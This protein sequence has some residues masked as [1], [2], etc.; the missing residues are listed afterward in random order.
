MDEYYISKDTRYGPS[1][2]K[3]NI[4]WAEQYIYD[5]L[6]MEQEDDVD[7]KELNHTYVLISQHFDYWVNKV[8]LNDG[9]F[10]TYEFFES[11]KDER[12]IYWALEKTHKD[13]VE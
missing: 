8:I 3:M 1:D 13:I 5:V 7:D 11:I 10:D 4:S 2:I 12:N 9:K 6:R